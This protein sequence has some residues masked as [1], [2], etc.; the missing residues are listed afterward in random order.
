MKIAS[1]D[2]DCQ[3]TFSPLCPNEL[4]VPEGDKIVDELNKQAKLA[5]IRVMTK[6]AHS[7]KAVWAVEEASK[8]FQPVGKPNSDITW[9]RHAEVGSDGFELLPGLP[10]ADEYDF[11][12]YKGVE[13]DMHPYGAC[14]HDLDE[15]IS[16]GLIEFLKASKVDVVLVGGL[17]TDYCVKNTVLQLLKNG[18]WKVVLNEGAARGI[19]PDTVASA[20]E[21]MKKAGCHIVKNADEAKKLVESFA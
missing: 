8:Q 9:L 10:K 15:K 3:K 20:L 6:D 5:D 19:A 4:P 21:D 17:A 11:L 2:V 18:D 13:R 14:F 7:S 16:T 1:I 12:V